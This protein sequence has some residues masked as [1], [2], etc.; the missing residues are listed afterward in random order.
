M[1]LTLSQHP[2]KKYK[3]EIGQMKNTHK[4]IGILLVLVMLLGAATSCSSQSGTPSTPPSTAP[5]TDSTAE[6]SESNAPV[7]KQYLRM[8]AGPSGGYNYTL[9]AGIA[10]LAAKEYP[11]RYDI[12]V[13]ISTGTSENARNIMM[14][15]AQFGMVGL[16]VVKDAYDATGEFEGMEAGQIQHIISGPAAVVHILT[17]E[18]SGI[19]TVE[20][21]VGKKVGVGKGVMSTYLPILFEAMG[22][23]ADSTSMTQLTITDICNGLADGTIDAGLYGTPYPTSSISDLSMTSALKLIPIP[24]ETVEKVAEAYPFFYADTI[25]A[26]S[27]N[28][29]DYDTPTMSRRSAIM[30]NPNVPEDVVYDILKVILE[31]NDALVRI[32]AD[33]ASLNLDNALSGLQTPLHPGAERYYRE[34]G[35]ID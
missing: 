13:D 12:Q 1:F 28:G 16:D 14:G 7:Q 25:P 22:L 26:G 32:H 4:L 3:K 29:V 31:Q 2:K 5:E 9:F 27:Y 24:V 6:P 10:D 21:L 8:S 20:D 18:G 11:G 34:A 19:E 33:S 17:I 30:T 15:E 23:S 35:L